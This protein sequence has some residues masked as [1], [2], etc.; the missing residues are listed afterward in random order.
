MTGP[1]IGSIAL[2]IALG[3]PVAVMPLAGADPATPRGASCQGDIRS[4][5]FDYWLG[6]WDVR[7]YGKGENAPLHQNVI[8]LE[9]DGC[10]IQEHW[11]GAADATGS[12]YTGTSLT[13][14]DRSRG[15]WHQT[16]VD[17]QGALAV[18]EGAPDTKGDLVLARLSLP[19]DKADGIER[20]MSYRKQPDGSVRQIVERSKDGGTTWTTAIDLHYRRRSAG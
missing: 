5:A 9:Q 6:T 7:P 16:W 1:T 19:G 2:V 12:R 10:V 8:T 11:R 20:R 15:V 13:V 14:F 17:N 18:F 4:T 3:V